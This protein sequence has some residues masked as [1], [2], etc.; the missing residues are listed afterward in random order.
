MYNY[1]VEQVEENDSNG[2]VKVKK[3]CIQEL[4]LFKV[5]SVTHMCSV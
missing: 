2:I 4:L 5:T 1:R 3:W